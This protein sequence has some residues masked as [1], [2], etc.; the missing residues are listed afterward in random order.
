M[1]VGILTYHNAL[2]YGAVLQCYALQ[3]TMISNGFD[4]EVLDYKS[5]GIEQQYNRIKLGQCRSIKQFIAHNTTCRIRR[6]K[7]KKFKAFLSK[8]LKLSEVIFNLGDISNVDCVIVGSDQVWN[9][10]CNRGDSSY[11]LSNLPADVKRIAY[12][13]S[14][15][16]NENIEL[17]N[18]NYQIDY[19]KLLNQFSFIS[20]REKDSVEFFKNNNLKSEFVVDP[21]LLCDRN[22]W[23]SMIAPI[24]EQYIFVYNLGN[25]DKLF[26]IVQDLKKITK[27]KVKIVNQNIKGTL[28]SFG[29]EDLSNSSPEEFISLLSNA[30]Y[31]I[32]DSFHGTAFSLIFHKKFYSIANPR[33]NSANNR[34]YS[35]LSEVGLAGR[36]LNIHDNICISD[37]I[38]YDDVDDILRSM[39]LNS[40]SLLLNGINNGSNDNESV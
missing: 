37:E 24:E 30:K 15:G 35:L 29:Y 7:K 13:A 20:L 25:Y 27:L 21:V 38:D 28:R 8:N 34:L 19:V 18:V 33:S 6:L 9:P 22:V 16:K 10:I 5:N 12:A 26:D 3:Q 2:N 23:Q 31:V 4:C 14:I 32:T 36:F 17:Y 1:N 39:K 11:L 40:L